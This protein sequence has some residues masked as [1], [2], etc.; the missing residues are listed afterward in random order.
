MIKFENHHFA[1][2]NEM[3]GLANDNEVVLKLFGER[4]LGNFWTGMLTLS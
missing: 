4:L 2:P 1:H 3:M